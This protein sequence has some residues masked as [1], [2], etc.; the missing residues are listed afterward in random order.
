MI[1]AETVT[2]ID[3]ALKANGCSCKMIAVSAL[4]HAAHSKYSTV[5]GKAIHSARGSPAAVRKIQGSFTSKPF[6]SFNENSVGSFSP[7]RQPEVKA[8]A[9]VDSKNQISRNQSAQSK[10]KDVIK[11]R[12]DSDIFAEFGTAVVSLFGG[13]M[14]TEQATPTSAHERAF[15]RQLNQEVEERLSRGGADGKGLFSL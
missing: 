2:A 13:A 14:A 9:Y 4:V 3:I 6:N 8:T 11:G 1:N 15:D 7:Y 10:K 12:R 5:F